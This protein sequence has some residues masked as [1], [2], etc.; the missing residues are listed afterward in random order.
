MKKITFLLLLNL[1]LAFQLQAQDPCKD[2]LKWSV[3][4]IF[5][6]A[7]NFRDV[8]GKVYTKKD[9]MLLLLFCIKN[10]SEEVYPAG[11]FIDCRFNLKHYDDE[12]FVNSIYYSL[13]K[14]FHPTDSIGFLNFAFDLPLY[15]LPLGKYTYD[16]FI[17]ATSS[18][19]IFCDSIQTLSLFTAVFDLVDTNNIT[20]YAKVNIEVFPIPA[21]SIIDIKSE[22]VQIKEVILYNIMGKKMRHYFVN[23]N[24]KTLDVSDL[25]NGMYFIKIHTDEGVLTRKIQIMR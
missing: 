6:R 4:G 19:G 24:N 18:D 15:K 1:I 7:D 25:N 23:E 10:V 11:T 12:I 14:D 16:M 9:S 2:T 5:D 17:K 13:K 20:T 21:N 3:C 22:N 8:D